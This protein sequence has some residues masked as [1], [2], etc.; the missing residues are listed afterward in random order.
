MTH[1]VVDTQG[2]A[3][4][5]REAFQAKP[6]RRQVDLGF[7]WPSEVIP[8]G[9]AKAEMYISNKWQKNPNKTEMYKHVAE[10]WQQCYLNPEVEVYDDHGDPVEF[11][12]DAQPLNGPMPKHIAHLALA[13]GIQVEF[14]NGECHQ[15][16]IPKSYWGAAK[17]P[18]TGETFLVLYTNERICMI[19]T[20]D[21]LDVL[22]DGI[23]G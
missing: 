1:R 3:K 23:V 12:A 9:H 5:I 2:W 17:H 20:G 21:D 13:M 10:A 7:E 22:A 18:K 8:I 15:I 11:C 16:E 4:E 19:L 14:D 6:V